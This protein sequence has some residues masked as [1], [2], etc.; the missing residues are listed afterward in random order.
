MLGACLLYCKTYNMDPSAIMYFRAPY[1]ESDRT[2]YG[3]VE[4]CLEHLWGVTLLRFSPSP[5]ACFAN[6]VLFYCDGCASQKIQLR[7][8]QVNTMV[9]VKTLGG[10][11]TAL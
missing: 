3:S 8:L 6:R 4:N 1:R 2:T 5:Q 7:I 11:P 10:P 9:T